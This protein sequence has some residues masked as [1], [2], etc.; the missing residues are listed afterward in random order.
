MLESKEES[1]IALTWLQ[2]LM[3]PFITKIFQKDIYSLC[4]SSTFLNSLEYDFLGGF[5]TGI[6][7]KGHYDL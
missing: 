6:A 1:Y 3:F 4:P 5:L 7:T 2:A